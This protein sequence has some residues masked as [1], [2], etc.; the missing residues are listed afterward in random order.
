MHPVKTAETN[1]ELTAP[2]EAQRMLQHPVIPCEAAAIPE[3]GQKVVF[4]V[5]DFTEQER[6]AIAQGAQVKFAQ[7]VNREIPMLD[8]MVVEEPPLEEPE[9]DSESA[10]ESPPAPA[11]VTK[12]HLPGR[13][14]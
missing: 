13:D 14:F 11:S 3:T 6:E 8:A 12:L 9:E 2:L 7:A 1:D 4:T 5:W 10:E